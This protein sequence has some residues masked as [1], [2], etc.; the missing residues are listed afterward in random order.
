MKKK[1][2]YTAV[3]SNSFEKL[4]KFETEN[5]F[6]ESNYKKENKRK[7]FFNLG[8]ENDW[9]K[10]LDNEISEKYRKRI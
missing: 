9:K 1:K 3:K 2:F 4:K 6:S 5:G 10:L 7:N 8:P